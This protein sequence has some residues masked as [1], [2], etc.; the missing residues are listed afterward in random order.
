MA[1]GAC[2]EPLQQSVEKKKSSAFTVDKETD[3]KE[4]DDMFHSFSQSINSSIN[5]LISSSIQVCASHAAG[6]FR[7]KLGTP[8][9]SVDDT[10]LFSLGPR[11][12]RTERA[13]E[14]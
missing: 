9:T 1:L 2:D 14:S 11:G 13:K 4:K 8:R 10:F 7:A 6:P 3:K 12:R 5:Q